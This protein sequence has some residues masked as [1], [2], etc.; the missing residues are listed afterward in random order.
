MSALKKTI[1]FQDFVDKGYTRFDSRSCAI[2]VRNLSKIDDFD[3][4]AGELT[5]EF[6]EN[7]HRINSVFAEEFL[8]SIISKL[9]SFK[10]FQE[11][12]KF[13]GGNYSIKSTI[14]DT[15]TH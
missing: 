10:H 6:P 8:E 14:D 11:K 7:L 13:V 4:T 5:I 12:V 1:N 15:V 3:I 9:R 2:A